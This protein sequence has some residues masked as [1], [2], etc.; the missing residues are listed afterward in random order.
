MNPWLKK[1]PFSYIYKKIFLD[2]FRNVCTLKIHALLV[3]FGAFSEPGNPLKPISFK[4][5][6][7]AGEPNFIRINFLF[8]EPEF[9]GSETFETYFLTLHGALAEPNESVRFFINFQ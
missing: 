9:M 5:L 6:F 4:H 2:S 7:D 1:V 8:V 3:D